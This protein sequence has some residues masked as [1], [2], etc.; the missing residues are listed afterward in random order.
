MIKKKF[1]III[2]ARS[3]SSKLKNKN[4]RLVN[5]KPLLYYTCK[6]ANQLKNKNNIIVGCA[7]SKKINTFFTKCGILA[8]FL[9]P[10]KISKK[11]SLDIE[12]VNYT[13]DFYS[14]KEIFFHA[15]CIL[16][17]TS[18]IRFLKDYKE[19]ERKFLKNKS[20]TSLRSIMKSPVTP[21]K[22]WNKK[23]NYI[24]PLLKSKL[25]EH[26]NMPRQKLPKIYWQTGTYDFFKINFKKKLKTI[27]GNK[28]IFHDLSNRE[29]VDIDTIG[30]IK[31]V[32]NFL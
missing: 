8:P 14:R 32:I 18:P 7:D 1:L 17:P 11:F 28:I 10:K 20:A 22:M 15:G 3:G 5:N 23:G 9:R 26:Y 2:P 25:K 21:Y 16:R 19:A 29:N 24:Y 31:K 13:L 30:D 4:M 12:Y 27:T 6:F